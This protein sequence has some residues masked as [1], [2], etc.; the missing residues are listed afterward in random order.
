MYIAETE[1]FS[2][3]TSTTFAIA[4]QL[5]SRQAAFLIVCTIFSREYVKFIVYV[6]VFPRNIC[7]FSTVIE[8]SSFSIVF[9][10]FFQFLTEQ[11]I[12]KRWFIVANDFM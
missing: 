9:F 8:L 2:T 10:Y 7:F 5:G 4:P 12:K 3:I 6:V 11:S 1:S